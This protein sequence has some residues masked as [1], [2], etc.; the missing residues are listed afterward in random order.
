MM[1]IALALVVHE[2]VDSLQRWQAEAATAD[3]H[4]L[5]GHV[6]KMQVEK[7]TPPY[8]DSEPTCLRASR[9]VSI[10]P[11]DGNPPPCWDM[12]PWTTDQA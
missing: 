10:T 4:S 3:A 7:K 11:N 12:G 5:Q 6:W 2:S 8:E 1:S 9:S